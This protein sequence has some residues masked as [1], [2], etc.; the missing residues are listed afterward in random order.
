MVKKENDRPRRGRKRPKASRQPKVAV[1]LVVQGKV[2]EVQYFERLRKQWE[3]PNL[4]ILPSSESPER[5]IDSTFVKTDRDSS[6]RYSEVFLVVDVDDTIDK[7]FEQA[8]RA[9]RLASRGKTR[10]TFVVSNESFE[11]WLLGHVQDIRRRNMGRKEIQQ[12]LKKQHLLEGAKGKSLSDKFPISKVDDAI[13]QVDLCDYND[14]G[15]VCST[16]VPHLVCRLR[17]LRISMR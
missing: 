11:T 16:A 4:R 8:F 1:M 17:K 12:V 13:G 3:I 6:A 9:A 10:Y 7:Q 2:T 15:K 5:M 14:V